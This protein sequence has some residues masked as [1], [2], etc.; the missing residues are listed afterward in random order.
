MSD[1]IKKIKIKQSDGT[2]SDYIPIGADAK[3]IDLQSGENVEEAIKNLQNTIYYYNSVEDMKADKKIKNGM[4]CQTLGYY[5]PNDGGGSKYLITDI[6]ENQNTNFYIP[7][8]NQNLYARTIFRDDGYINVKKLGA[9]GDWNLT[10]L[11][12]I[13]NTIEDAQKVYPIADSLDLSIDWC[14]IQTAINMNLGK[15]YL[16]RGSYY[17]NKT[18]TLL[19]NSCIEGDSQRNTTINNRIDDDANNH[20]FLLNN[21]NNITI[22]N[23][24]ITRIENEDNNYDNS[25]CGIYME[26]STRNTFENLAFFR[27]N[28]GIRGTSNTWEQRIE[29]CYFQRCTY[30]IYSS[31]SAANLWTVSK[32]ITEYCKNGFNFNEGRQI[33]IYDSDFEN[34]ENGAITKTGEGDIEIINCYFEMCGP[35]EIRIYWGI[36]PTNMAKISGCSFFFNIENDN[37]APRILVHADATSSVT[38][39]SCHFKQTNEENIN[40]GAVGLETA[41]SNIKI[42]MINNTYINCYPFQNSRNIKNLTIIDPNIGNLTNKDKDDFSRNL[43]FNESGNA[44]LDYDSYKNIFISPNAEDE[45]TITIN[46]D[47]RYAE[48]GKIFQIFIRNREDRIKPITIKAGSNVVIENSSNANITDFTNFQLLKIYYLYR[49]NYN[50]YR[51]Y[52]EK[53]G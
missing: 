22:R 24:S 1:R 4:L 28:S 46:E 37:N 41:N 43:E 7:V 44:F 14:A 13:F 29:N 16:P 6:I 18:F 35:Q 26:S 21:V 47:Q 23:M 45:Y 19:N 30:G 20:V 9:K 50:R 10:S 15:V 8:E 11:S 27:Q 39:E 17:I 32:C 36:R 42:A 31:G 51:F 52:I 53:I 2:F 33:S 49:D 5:K 25:G 40:C 12:S 38:I 34:M 48:Y 3:N